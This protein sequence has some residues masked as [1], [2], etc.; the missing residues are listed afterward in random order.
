MILAICVQH[1]QAYQQ[2]TNGLQTS[3]NFHFYDHRPFTLLPPIQGLKNLSQCLTTR[4]PDL[5]ILDKRIPFFQE[6][7]TVCHQLKIKCLVFEGDLQAAIREVDMYASFSSDGEPES[8]QSSTQIPHPKEVVVKIGEKIVEK[9]VEKLRYANIPQ[10]VIMIGSLWAGAGSTLYSVNLAKAI[11]DRHI[12]VSYVEFPK[13]K[14]YVFDYLNF[15]EL[16]RDFDTPYIDH[17]KQSLLEPNLKFQGFRY[18][19]VQWVVNDSR[20]PPVD[21]WTSDHML[22]LIYA[23]RD[24]PI[25]IVDISEHWADPEIQRFLKHV[26][27]IYV[28]IEPDPVK[29]ERTSSFENQTSHPEK[30][31]DE[32]NVIEFLQTLKAEGHD[33]Q[34]IEMKMNPKIKFRTWRECLDKPPV[35]SLNYIPYDEV[36]KSVWE[37]SFLY[38]CPVYKKD[39][40]K[41]FLPILSSILP[42][43]YIHLKGRK[44]SFKKWVKRSESK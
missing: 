42:K 21:E 34:Y 38:D 20:Y 26:D 43:K 24:T 5:L 1:P 15:R 37:S 6:A 40:E 17:A 29:I 27:D 12:E 22:K 19:G 31:T 25:V 9:E 7:Y 35:T 30:S 36:L 44:A 8:P 39:F 18:Q 33:Y 2:L 16:E 4:Q 10:K 23:M 3:R 11:A 13:I 41:S 28:C 32:H 14:P